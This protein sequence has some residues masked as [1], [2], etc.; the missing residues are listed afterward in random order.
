MG[1]AVTQSLDQCWYIPHLKPAPG[2][3]GCVP[4][5][6]WS[7]IWGAAWKTGIACWW[8]IAVPVATGAGC[9]A[10]CGA[11]VV[12]VRYKVVHTAARS[13]SPAFAAS[14]GPAI[15]VAPYASICLQC[16]HQVSLHPGMHRLVADGL[17]LLLGA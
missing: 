16:R 17:E 8:A 14:S 7:G 4:A 5:T 2:G 12:T 13:T 1:A 6:C 10:S 3:P 11:L 15:G 9:E